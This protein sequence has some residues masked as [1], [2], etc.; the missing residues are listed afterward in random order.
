MLPHV[1]VLPWMPLVK[2]VPP[3]TSQPLFLCL[4]A[5]LQ[6]I[7]KNWTPKDKYASRLLSPWKGFLP[8]R[9]WDDLLFL[10]VL[11]KIIYNLEEF[12][13]NP[14]QLNIEPIKYF[15]EWSGFVPWEFIEEIL[16]E[17]IVCK[18]GS[19]VE[20]WRGRVSAADQAEWVEGWMMFFADCPEAIQTLVN[21]K[22]CRL[23]VDH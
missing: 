8:S 14:A 15:I 3:A 18:I 4:A 17:Y 6:K 20:S 22:L 13:P 2:I 12:S 19:V 11:P 5:K 9:M 7:L 1:W 23:I 16:D 21:E 10:Q